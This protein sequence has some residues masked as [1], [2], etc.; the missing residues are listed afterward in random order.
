MLGRMGLDGDTRKF[1]RL[2]GDDYYSAKAAFDSLKRDPSKYPKCK[3]C[4]DRI[5]GINW[6]GY[7]LRCF[8]EPL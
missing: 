5:T 1:K 3:V 4:G 7:D 8:D 2:R 6:N